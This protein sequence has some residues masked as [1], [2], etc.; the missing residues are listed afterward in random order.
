MFKGE[1]LDPVTGQYHHGGTQGLGT[2]T[3][4]HGASAPKAAVG[5]P[6]AKGHVPLLTKLSAAEVPQLKR[7]H[8]KDAGKAS[9]AAEAAAEMAVDASVTVDSGGVTQPP[10]HDSGGEDERAKTA[11]HATMGEAVADVVAKVDNWRLEQ[12]TLP[13][14]TALALAPPSRARY[15]DRVQQQQVAPSSESLA[16]H[17]AVAQLA[18]HEV[19]VRASD[20]TKM[21]YASTGMEVRLTATP[22]DQQGGA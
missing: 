7:L 3:E 5:Q 8:G 10:S 1:S 2:K 11:R 21:V 14:P 16:D 13:K 20:G 17:E 22:V 4:V 18:D 12:D 19:P 9:T 6:A 15:L